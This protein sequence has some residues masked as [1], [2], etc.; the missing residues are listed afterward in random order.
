VTEIE[1]LKKQLAEAKAENQSLMLRL[2]NVMFMLK[3][4]MT[5]SESIPKARPEPPASNSDSLCPPTA[6]LR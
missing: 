2:N 4:E 1:L 3:Q 6:P 5:A